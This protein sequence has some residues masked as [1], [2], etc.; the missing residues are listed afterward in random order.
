MWAGCAQSRRRCGRGAP[1]PGA[2]VGGVR[3]VRRRCGRGAPSPGADVGGCAQSR[4]RF[5]QGRARSPCRRAQ[6][7]AHCRCRH[8]QGRARFS[9]QTWQGEPNL[10]ADV[11]GVSQVPVQA[12]AHWRR[13]RG[14]CGCGPCR[15]DLRRGDAPL[16]RD[17]NVT[18]ERMCP[19]RRTRCGVTVF[20]S[21][22]MHACGHTG[23]LAGYAC[24]YS[25]S[26]VI[27]G[28]SRGTRGILKGSAISI[29]GCA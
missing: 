25:P 24:E 2:D 20:W 28:S 7:R 11:A 18:R 19:W 15:A 5:T 13:L 14:A 21:E 9:A 16:R 22:R 12:A 1:S 23:A 8:G 6:R 17:G 3:P 29:G 27:E 10:G 26:P 4:R